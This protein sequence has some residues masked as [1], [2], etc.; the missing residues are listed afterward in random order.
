MISVQSIIDAPIEKVWDLWTLPKHI[1]KW[2]YPSE[3]WQTIAAE[4]DLKING[5]FKYIMQTKDKSAAFDF[6][7]IY[8]DVKVLSKIEYKL[9]DNR[10][11]S[12][13]FEENDN[14]V[15]ITEIFEPNTN[16]SKSMQEQWCQAVIDNFKTYVE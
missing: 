12:I 4:N 3:E 16:D 15:K 5:K 1:V 9:F 8:T 10:T 11:G 2:N 14:I 7:G 6:E 13:H